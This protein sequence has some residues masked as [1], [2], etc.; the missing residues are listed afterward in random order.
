MAK[1]RGWV[2]TFQHDQL[3]VALSDLPAVEQTLSSFGVGCKGIDKNAA[4]GMALVRDLTDVP[5]AVHELAQRDAIGPELK[6]YR[7]E[8]GRAL[9]CPVADLDLLIKGIRIQLSQQFPGWEV[10]IGKN[11]GPSLVKGYP[12]VNGGGDGE[13]KFTD[14]AFSTPVCGHD[15]NRQRGRGVRVGLLD[16][17]MF[18]DQ[19][20]AGH[21]IAGP[22]DVLNSSHK[23]PFTMFDGHCAFVGSC[24]LQQAPAAELVVRH[25]LNKDGEGWAWEAA[26]AM[27]EVAQMG[28]DVVNLSFGEFLTDDN[29]APMVLEAG[30]KRFSPETVVVAAAGNNGDAEE[31]T[32]ELVH[33]GVKTN[34][35]S[36]PAALPDVVGVGALDQ[37][38][39][40]AAFTPHP[41]PWIALLATGVNLVGAYVDGKV[42][43]KRKNKDD[44]VIE[45]KT[46]Y[47]QGRANWE[48]CSFA[49]GV[50]SG[51][52]AARTVPGRR[53]ARRALNELLH[54]GPGKSCP[55][56]LPN[57]LDN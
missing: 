51:E 46:V 36:Y 53:P 29:T 5:K 16:T 33:E 18:P 15:R 55:G 34:S 54:P 48:G 22:S 9:P 3:V 27:A 41:A 32:D 21:Y 6:R 17:R 57:S 43:L 38:G 26:T 50:V 37:E 39:K 14:A 1:Q 7:A 10:T 25:V 30:V 4:L 47:F 19:S 8:R 44:D 35:A 40:R 28:L 52:I 56:I 2:E 42:A 24:I 12:H 13:P 11:Y 49:A 45:K 31:L 20:L 23:R